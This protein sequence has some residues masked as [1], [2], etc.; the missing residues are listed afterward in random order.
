MPASTLESDYLRGVL[1][2]LPFLLVLAP[3]AMLFGVVATEAGLDLMQV[4]GFSV[5]VIAG[6]AQFTAL[7]LMQQDAPVWAVIATALAVNLRMAMYSAALVPFLGPAPLWQRALVAYINVD[8][9]FGAAASDYELRPSLGVAQRM[10]FFAGLATPVIP[11][12][13]GFTLLGARLG[14]GMPEGW[15]LDFALPITFLAMIGPMLKT[16]AHVAAA[17]V[18]IVLSLALAGLPSGLGLLLAGLAAMSTGALVEVATERR[19]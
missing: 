10:R 7:Q 16:L 3:F 8:Q 13:Y 1:V 18:S 17:A 4:M 14:S 19:R 2:S 5:V 9:T 11:C 12:W 15:A 6:A